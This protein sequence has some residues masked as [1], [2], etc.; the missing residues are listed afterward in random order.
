MIEC[1]IGDRAGAT[2]VATDGEMQI[3]MT[4]RA[5]LRGGLTNPGDGG[6]KTTTITSKTGARWSRHNGRAPDGARCAEWNCDV[7]NGAAIN[8]PGY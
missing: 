2:P 6:D 4:D 8:R 5:L 1:W 3:V 7:E